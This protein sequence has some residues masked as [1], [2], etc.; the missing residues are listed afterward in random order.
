MLLERRLSSYP[1]HSYGFAM[2]RRRRKLNKGGLVGGVIALL[3]LFMLTSGLG[4]LF[5]LI[6]FAVGAYM[7][8]TAKRTVRQ[9]PRTGIV[10][11]SNV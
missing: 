11:T 2:R 5:G 6:V 3:G 9:N 1:L 8:A 4:H 7:I 10:R